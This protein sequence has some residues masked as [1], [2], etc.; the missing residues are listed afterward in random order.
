MYKYLSFITS[1]VLFIF[2]SSVHGEQLSK[3]LEEELA[4]S[5]WDTNLII[6]SIASI[7][8]M[9]VDA[10]E[11]L[12]DVL[13]SCLP[14]KGGQLRDYFCEKDKYTLQ[15]RHNVPHSVNLIINALVAASNAMASQQKF[16]SEE[17]KQYFFDLYKQR[18]LV[19]NKISDAISQR[20]AFN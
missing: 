7:N 4:K 9:P 1:F 8:N 16:T 18:E 10:V 2:A 3:Y 19:I 17:Q 15:V 14:I 12:S 20:L 11:N 13:S 6:D 5:L